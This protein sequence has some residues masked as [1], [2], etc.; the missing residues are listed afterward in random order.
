MG[1]HMNTKNNQR[2]RAMDVRLKATMLHLLQ[3]TPFESITVTKVC[4]VAGV[5]RSTFY[6]HYTDLFDMLGQIETRL[7]QELSE[8]L[9]EVDVLSKASLTLFLR[10][11]RQHHF[12]YQAVLRHHP[13]SVRFL[14]ADTMYQHVILPYCR[15]KGVTGAAEAKYLLTFFQAGFTMVLRQWVESGCA[16]NEDAMTSLL[17]SCFPS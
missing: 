15:R 12:F 16:E 6:A 11:V 7:R 14:D 17:F 1:G 5:N 9:A 10:H 3:E 2:F 13:E 8:T 4:Q